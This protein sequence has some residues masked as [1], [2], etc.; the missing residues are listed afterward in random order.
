M[1]LIVSDLRNKH[2]GKSAFCIGTA[3]HLRDLDLC[4]LKNEV[5]IVANQLV[6]YSDKYNFKYV[7]FN[8][9]DRLEQFKDDLPRTKAKVV[10]PQR[11]YKR[12]HDLFAMDENIVPVNVRLT[13]SS[14][15]EFFSFDLP[16]CAYAVDVMQLQIQLA[17]WMGC[18]PIYLLGVDAAIKDFDNHYFDSLVSLTISDPNVHVHD[19]T[20]LLEWLQAAKNT[21]WARG[22]RLIN[23]AGEK[24]SLRVLPRMRL[25]A[26]VGKPR[27]AVTSKTFSADKY[28]VSELKRYFPNIKVNTSSDKLEG[29]KLVDFLSDADG[30]VLGTEPFT[31]EVIEKL[32]CLRSVA[33]YGVGLDNVDFDAA[34]Q[35]DV[36]IAYRK[37]MNSHSVA[38]LT[39]A[40]AIMAL[41][42]IDSSISAYR[43]GTWAKLPGRELGEISVGMIG[44]GQ[45]GRVVAQKFAQLGVRRLLVSDLVDFPTT[46]PVEFVPLN[47]LLKEADVVSI[48]IDMRKGNYHFADSDFLA[49]MKPGA[50]LINT[51]RGDVLDAVALAKV[52]KDGHLSFAAL[53]VYE[54][55]PKINPDLKACPNLL[56]TCHIAGSSD[57]AIKNMGFAAIEGLLELFSIEAQ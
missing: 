19:I 10:L 16:A 56:T 12:Y 11:L 35:H 53:D 13:S 30:M 22:I 47:Y 4:Q 14:H 23:G 25:E 49:K 40:F 5:T 50:I 2:V 42:H 51:S 45:V 20:N 54:D 36:Q 37:G 44:Y 34:K 8:N 39:L 26:A 24:S 9:E 57:R 1:A 48:H 43:S 27:I 52:L 46:P 38:E 41:R 32:P 15:T 31:R 17:A 29:A 28:L 55:E 18:S 33:K 3:P 21:L 7:C 6:R